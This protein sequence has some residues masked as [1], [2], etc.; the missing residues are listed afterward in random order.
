MDGPSTLTRFAWLSI[1]AAVLTISLKGA[2]YFLTGSVGLLSDALES[3][4]NLVAAMGALV[5][6]TVVERE[7]SEEHA[8]G[9][10]KAEYFASGLEGALILVAAVSI[11]AAAVPRLLSPGQIEEVG[12]GLAVSAF[13]SLIN[14]GVGWRLLQAGREYRSITLEADARHLLTDVWTS[15]GVIVGVAAVAITGWGWLD[16]V[17]ALLVAANIV[18]TGVSLLRR[19]ALSLLDRALPVEERATIQTVLAGYAHEQGIQWHALRTQQAGRRRFVSVHILVPGQWTVHRGHQLLERIE[20]DLR[21]KL[22]MTTMFTHL[23]SL[24]DPSSWADTEL[25]RSSLPSPLAPEP[26]EQPRPSRAETDTP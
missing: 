20:A 21:T 9:Y 13:A 12:L 2:A 1:F 7:P 10:E 19:S 15:A 4:V 14:L 26:N 24:D 23:E 6:L 11:I 8:F 17:V 25:D 3:L 16:P 18:W 5:A 22:P